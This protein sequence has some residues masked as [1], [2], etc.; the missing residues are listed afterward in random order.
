MTPDIDFEDFIEHKVKTNETLDCLAKKQGITWK[1]L[2][3]FNWGTSTPKEINE[4][5]HDLVGC[6]RKTKNGKNYMFTS[7]DSPGIICIP[8]KS[9][10]F[11][12]ET[13]RTHRIQ[14]IRP[15][16]R[17]N[18]EVETVDDFLDVVGN[19]TLVLKRQEG[20]PDVDVTTD[21][22]GY[23]VAT[24]VLSGHYKVTVKGGRPAYFLKNTQNPD[25]DDPNAD[26]GDFTEAV[27]D[28]R[29]NVEALTQLVV[30]RLATPVQKQQRWLLQKIYT[31]TQ[32]VA[33]HGRG[34]AR[35]SSG[36]S[37][38][39]PALAI[40]NLAIAAGWYSSAIDVPNLV[41]TVLSDF[42][43]G[44]DGAPDGR[45]YYVWV[46]E[47]TAQTPLISLYNSSGHREAAFPL[48]SNVNGLVGAYSVF[49]DDGN[50]L[51]VDMMSKSYSPQVVG[52][53][54]EVVPIEEL[55]DS[56][57]RQSL[58]N[59]ANAHAG[60]VAVI[61]LL[62]ALSELQSIAFHGGAGHLEDYGNQPDINERIHARNLLVCANIAS[63]YNAYIRGYVAEVRKKNNVK[64]LRK[65]E[66]AGKRGAPWAPYLMPAPANATPHLLL[67]IYSAYDVDQ[68]SAW[69]AIAVRLDKFANRMSEGFPYISLKA[70]YEVGVEL[71]GAKGALIRAAS[72][73]TSLNEPIPNSIEIEGSLTF[74]FTDDDLRTIREHEEKL[75]SSLEYETKGRHK[76]SIE[77]K[78][79]LNKPGVT[80]GT[81]KTGPLEL[82]A[83][84][85]GKVKAAWE[86]FPEIW[87]ESE[88]NPLNATFEGGLKIET[89][90]MLEAIEKIPFKDRRIHHFFEKYGKK[91]IPKEISIHAGVVGSRQETLLAITSN[92]P[93]FFELRDLSDLIEARWNELDLDEQIHLAQLGWTQCSWDLKSYAGSE[94]PKT[95]EVGWDRF[96]S[97]QKV[98]LIHLGF[99][100]VEQYH[101]LIE[102][103]LHKKAGWKDAVQ[104]FQC[105]AEEG[106]VKEEASGSE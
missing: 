66:Y 100:G 105:A 91:I 101:E 38:F 39:S 84:T 69:R 85:E 55:V 8:I 37:R 88:V 104:K 60:Q 15:H 56:N 27:I 64:E 68:I 29:H 13:G 16:L 2:A 82:E 43:S 35:D 62:P 74:Q 103:S 23:G 45:D 93:G 14:V 78:R 95:M 51:F 7:K 21:V 24:Q 30:V 47:P 19:V 92:A 63:V 57:V 70:K 18:I 49:E 48:A 96:T 86:V 33:A 76:F 31:R 79:S 94:P 36:Y 58:V 97:Q 87:A 99:N 50:Q 34:A 28:T 42:F 12:L 22:N 9:P 40:D 89:G 90:A 32:E 102:E 26:V 65:I 5:L 3:Q 11:K 59:A 46:I 81:I 67:Q 6:H 25:N 72:G 52:R 17:T 54:G 44:R 41:S 61:Y 73:A 4:C 80:E 53:E 71:M 75:K 106:E 77:Y 1:Q 98:A 20:G 83:D 10:R